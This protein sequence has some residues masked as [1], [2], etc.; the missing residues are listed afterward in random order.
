[1][2]R[3]LHRHGGVVSGL[4]QRLYR[5]VS[6]GLSWMLFVITFWGWHDPTVYDAAL[7]YTLLHPVEHLSFLGTALLFWWHVSG[8]SPHTHGWPRSARLAYLIA[9]S[10]PVMAAGMFIAASGQPLYKHYTNVGRLWNITPLQGQQWGGMVMFATGGLMFV[11][12]GLI[13]TAQMLQEPEPEPPPPW[14]EWDVDET[15]G[16]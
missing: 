10:V 14:F 12:G 11:L 16:A 2:W 13:F 15:P 3:G 6:P 8:N 5:L 9:T 1:V 7:R 4:I